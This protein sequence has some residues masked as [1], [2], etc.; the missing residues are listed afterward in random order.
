MDYLNELLW[1]KDVIT[2]G[3]FLLNFTC[4]HLN[5]DSQTSGNSPAELI[6]GNEIK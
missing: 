6:H 2:K 3:S 1:D 4:W 5:L